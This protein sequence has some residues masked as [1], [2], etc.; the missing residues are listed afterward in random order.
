MAAATTLVETGA[1]LQL[2]PF[3]RW[4]SYLPFEHAESMLEQRRS[5]ALFAAMREDPV[6]GGAHEWAVRH[7]EVIERFGRFPHRNA[8]LGRISTPAELEYLEQ[9]GSGF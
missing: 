5:V 2:A 8:I 3:E 4:F 9:P 6:A 7:L 1:H